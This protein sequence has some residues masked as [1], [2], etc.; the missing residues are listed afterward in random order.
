MILVEMADAQLDDIISC[1]NCL[2]KEGYIINPLGLPC[3]H[4]MCETCL[5]EKA[6]DS[7]KIGCAVCK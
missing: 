3:E 5:P 4:P 2:E 1:G 7:V 6:S